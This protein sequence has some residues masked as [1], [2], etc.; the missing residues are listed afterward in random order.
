[1]PSLMFECANR[2]VVASGVTWGE[3]MENLGWSCVMCL[4]G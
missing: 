2:V 4:R 3:E 1:M